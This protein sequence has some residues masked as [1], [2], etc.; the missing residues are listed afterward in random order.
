MA[1]ENQNL[2]S[3]TQQKL[4]EMEEEDHKAYHRRLLYVFI[5]IML[6]LFGG[7]TFYYKSEK[8]RYLDA[9]Y[10]SAYTMTTV[11]YGDFVP[12]TDAGKV[13]TIFY[14]FAGVAI[15]LYGLSLMASHFVEI[16]E[17]FWLERINKIRISH[18]TQNIWDKLKGFFG[19]EPGKLISGYEK[20]VRN[21]R[22]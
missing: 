6:L 4:R 18:H 20:S 10:F 5:V 13:F 16:R 8:W 21:K 3:I 22:K 12:K 9:L 17:E 2:N 11:G 19:F 15:A 14:V 7:A 1:R